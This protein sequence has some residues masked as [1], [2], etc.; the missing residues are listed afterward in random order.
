MDLHPT[1]PRLTAGF[2]GRNREAL[3]K[4]LDDG[5]LIV[6]FAGKAPRRSADA[7]YPF[8]ADRN[9]FYL[10]G[11]EEPE[12]AY[13]ALKGPDRLEE[14][15]YVRPRDEL[16][17]RWTGLRASAA[18]AR[19]TT[20]IEDIRMVPSLEADLKALFD[21][22]RVLR[23]ALDLSG[24]D[25]HPSDDPVRRFANRTREDHPHLG[26]ENAHGRLGTLRS[27]KSPDEVSLVRE[28]AA[29]T[30]RAIDA[31]VRAIRPGA[32]EFE[33]AAAFQYSIALE[34]VPEPA[35]PSI[36]ASGRNVFQ[37]HYDLPAGRIQDGDLV[38]IDV[39]AS[40]GGLH[41]DISRSYPANGRFTPRQRALYD[42]V[43]Q[44]QQ[45]AFDAIRPGATF[46]T[47]NSQSREAA[48]LGLRDLGLV[49]DR[50]KVPDYFWHGVSH[51]LGMDVHDVGAHDASLVPGMVITVEPGLY[52]PEW[53]IGVRIE[54]DALITE[55]GFEN[56]SSMIPKSADA[57]ER[58][59]AAGA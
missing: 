1:A 36:V 42:L 10:T 57:I 35:F 54:D 12:A 44:C 48:F 41:A 15:L 49:E 2:F 58:L 21:S 51:H 19:G 33:A 31:M 50:D 27:V 24:Y 14:R 7:D 13:V 9:F 5:T 26:I 20:G 8:L 18:Q 25:A 30:G 59:M 56:L 32:M 17:E 38:Q 52:V 11:F 4:T 43:L 46:R 6:V 16:R 47:V 45:A 28:A 40:A 39:G 3:A 55:E 34:G 23:L 29:R 22:G 53:G 37:L